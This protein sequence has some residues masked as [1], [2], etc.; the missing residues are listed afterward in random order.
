MMTPLEQVYAQ[1][2]TDVFALVAAQHPQKGIETLLNRARLASKQNQT[3]LEVE[4]EAVYQGALARTQARLA[5]LNACPK[6]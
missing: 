6:P 1:K 2:L 4:L 5:L 3:P